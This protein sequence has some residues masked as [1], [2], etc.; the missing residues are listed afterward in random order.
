MNETHTKQTIITTNNSPEDDQADIA[1][2]KNRGYFLLQL[3]PDIR[4]Q[5]E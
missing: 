1:W 5:Q 4:K 3:N 2:V